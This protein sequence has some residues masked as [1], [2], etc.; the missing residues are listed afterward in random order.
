ME[1]ITAADL[2]NEIAQLPIQNT[3]AYVSGRARLKIVEIEKPEGPIRFVNVDSNGN[4]TSELRNVTTGQL[5]LLASVC[6][7]RPNYPLHIDRVLSAGGNTRSSLETLLVHTPHFFV[8]H[9]Q[10]V[11]AYSGE[12]VANLKHIM[13]CPN[14]THP[15]GEIAVKEFREVI[16][17]I[18]LGLD[19]GRID[20]ASLNRTDEFDSIEVQRT[21]A[22]M[23][24]ALIEIGRALNFRT[25][26]ARNDRGIRVGNS[27]M[28]DLPTVIKSLDEIDILY[29]AASKRAADL[30]DAIWFTDD[31]NRIPAV[32]EIEHSTGV[33]SG[34]TRMLKLRETLP[35]ILTTFVIVAPDTLRGKVTAEANQSIYR[36]LNAR[37]LPY[38]TVRE[39]FG[40]IH[41]YPLAG[42]VDYKFIYPFLEIITGH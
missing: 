31:G 12:T 21:H 26:I 22:Q 32:I 1:R 11:D 25:W 40:L 28:S 5:A 14:E 8:C 7:S 34:M 17:E 15:I 4:A 36:E 27:Q 38:S 2:V 35:S 42:A 23:Q 18:E 39:L 3:Y 41:R 20:D 13:W 9:P 19:F 37:Y 6:S 30:I 24:I 29:N 16:T 10:R 33:T